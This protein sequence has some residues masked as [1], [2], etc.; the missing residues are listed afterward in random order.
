MQ[1][2]YLVTDLGLNLVLLQDVVQNIVPDLVPNLGLFFVL[3]GY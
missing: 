1:D 2:L 3:Y